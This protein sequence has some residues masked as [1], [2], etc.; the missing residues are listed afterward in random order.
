MSSRR[1]DLPVAF[2]TGSR[3]GLGAEIAVELAGAG[4]DVILAGTVHDAVAD[5]AVER[6]RERGRRAAFIDADLGRL[7]DLADVAD[8]AR[9]AFGRIDCLVNNAAV[10]VDSRG[11]M[12]D[13]SPSS[14]DRLL[15]INV[16]SP[17]LLTQHVVRDMLDAGR[18]DSPISRS[19]IFISSNN[20]A[21]A[22][23][24]FAEYCISK[25]GLSMAAQLFALRLAAEGIRVF[26]VRP[27]ITRSDMSESS[28]HVY[29]GVI[30]SGD[31]VPMRQWGDPAD[32][33]RAVATIAS[34][35][36]PFSTGEVIHIDGGMHVP[37][38]IVPGSVESRR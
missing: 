19:I 33:G 9:E 21:V 13:A 25:A 34:G 22:S 38:F 29:N 5:R 36:L 6:V 35:G 16:Q 15:R 18:S 37:R 28:A 3:R 30:E 20:A 31:A 2:V 14:L 27:G 8:R 1:Q 24:F 10:Q 32:V 26:D 4:F 23:P 7:E 12:L 17:V 11:D